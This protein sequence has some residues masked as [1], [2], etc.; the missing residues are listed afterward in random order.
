MV[1]LV[2][3]VRPFFRSSLLVLGLAAGTLVSGL[4]EAPHAVAASSG[5]AARAGSTPAT[6]VARPLCTS[7]IDDPQ[8][9]AAIFSVRASRG[10]VATSFGFTAVLEERPAGG[11]W[12]PLTGT[13]SPAG[14]GSFQPASEGAAAMVRRINVRGLRMGSAYRLKVTFRWVTPSGKQRVVRRSP[15]CTVKE[16]RPNIG[17]IRSLAWTPGTRGDQVVYRAQLRVLRAVPFADRKITISVSQGA[18]VLGRVSPL[19]L[20]HGALVLI[21]GTL[22]TPGQDVT[23]RVDA[24]AP[25]IEESST[26]DNELTVPCAP[27]RAAG[28]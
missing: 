15:S 26:T 28:R 1:S 22:C 8:Q 10:P 5:K 14:L 19:P 16:L 27:G 12:T 24:G 3:V 11:T 18:T 2:P 17:I 6:Q 4:G 25:A 13:A 7:S 23:Y 9:R 20:Y 21:P